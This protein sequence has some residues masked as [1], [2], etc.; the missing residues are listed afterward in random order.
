V[1]RKAFHTACRSLRGARRTVSGCGA[2]TAY[3][4]NNIFK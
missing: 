3:D 1:P 2:M 4:E